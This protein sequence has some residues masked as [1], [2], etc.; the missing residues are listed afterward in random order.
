[1]CKHLEGSHAP[2]ETIYC[3][4]QCSTLM[5]QQCSTLMFDPLGS[6][7]HHSKFEHTLY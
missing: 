4:K 3:H 5:H 1:M 7:T 6:E 2:T